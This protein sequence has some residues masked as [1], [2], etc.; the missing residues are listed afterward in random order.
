MAKKGER[1]NKKDPDSRGS[2]GA[3]MNG[4]NASDS[5]SPA[6]PHIHEKRTIQKNR[7]TKN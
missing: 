6:K 5:K 4:D 3:I 1:R 7:G 2:K